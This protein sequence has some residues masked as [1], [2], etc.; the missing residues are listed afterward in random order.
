MV[1]IATR[2]RHSMAFCQIAKYEMRDWIKLFESVSS[3]EGCWIEPDGTVH[4]CDHA[5]DHHHADIALQHFKVVPDGEEEND[6]DRDD[7]LQMALDNRWIQF[8]ALEWG[9]DE[10]SLGLN[11]DGKASAVQCREVHSRVNKVLR[12]KPSWFSVE[13][14]SY[15]LST[16]SLEE[17][18]E[19]FDRQLKKG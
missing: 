12:M 15:F 8:S 11:W 5:T 2:V 1:I 6:S 3:Y 19:N 7:A 16:E 17:F 14:G 9:A 4:V 18:L 13:H 10:R